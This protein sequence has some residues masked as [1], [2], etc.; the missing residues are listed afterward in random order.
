MMDAIHH[1]CHCYWDN[2]TIFQ[3]SLIQTCRTWWNTPSECALENVDISKNRTAQNHVHLSWYMLYK[4]HVSLQFWRDIMLL[5]WLYNP[6]TYLQ[7]GPGKQYMCHHHR[8]HQIQ[9]FRDRYSKWLLLRF[10]CLKS[11]TSRL[12]TLSDINIRWHDTFYWN[13][14]DLQA[15]EIKNLIVN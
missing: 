2:G 3:V 13:Q 8:A 7:C 12:T 9:L 6:R 1:C 15:T 14:H 11:F 5:C 4:E 10:L